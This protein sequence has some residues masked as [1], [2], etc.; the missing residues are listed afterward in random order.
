MPE[1]LCSRSFYQRCREA[2]SPVGVLVANVQADTTQS[3]AIGQR[4]TKAFEGATLQVES[5]EGGNDIMTAVANR[6]LMEDAANGFGE[7]W[8]K[9][10]PV[11][12]Q[13]LAVTSTRLERALQKGR[14]AP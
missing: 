2:L 1:A 10:A 14:R 13:T 8:A 9:L 6:Q 4:L 12:Q 3:R 7:R 11:H 5:D